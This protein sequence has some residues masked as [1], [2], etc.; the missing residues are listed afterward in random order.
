[1]DG[2][3]RSGPAWAVRRRSR[4]IASARHLININTAGT[5]AL[6][7]ASAPARLSAMRVSRSTRQR[8]SRWMIGVLLLVQWLTSAYACPQARFEQPASAARADAPADP[9]AMA[10]CHGMTVSNMDPAN[11]ALCKAH[12]DAGTQ[13]PSAKAQGDVPGPSLVAL[14]VAAPVVHDDEAAPGQARSDILFGAPP[15][16]PPLYVIH[17][18]LR[19]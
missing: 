13:A 17:Q 6:A 19:N 18:V 9:A 10:D 12:C 8:V 14:V 15:G 16:W 1:M 5:K 4:P 11:P 3:V 2:L 7:P